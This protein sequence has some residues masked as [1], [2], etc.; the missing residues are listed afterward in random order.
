VKV[1]EVI[2]LIEDDGWMMV[3]QT[4]SHRAFRHAVKPGTTTVAGNL[5]KEVKPGTLANIL[6]QAGLRRPR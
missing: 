4:G 1:R 5:G 2:K 6:R 3:R